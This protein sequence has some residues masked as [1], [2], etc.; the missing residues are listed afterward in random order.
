VFEQAAHLLGRD[1]V[2]HQ[3]Q[4][5]GDER[6]GLAHELFE[7]QQAVAARGQAPQRDLARQFLT[8][9]FRWHEHPAQH[10]DAAQEGTGLALQQHGAEGADHHDGKCGRLDQR[11]ELAAVDCQHQADYAGPVH[12]CSR[13]VVRK[14]ATA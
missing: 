3:A 8:T 4:A 14:R 7:R 9:V 2:D 11:R 10:G 5:L 1:A 13:K 6:V 12:N